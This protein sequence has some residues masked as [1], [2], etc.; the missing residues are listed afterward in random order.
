MLPSRSSSLK[1]GMD[2]EEAEYRKLTKSER[3]YGWS[4]AAKALVATD[5]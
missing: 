2:E 3:S 1:S 5:P 4:R